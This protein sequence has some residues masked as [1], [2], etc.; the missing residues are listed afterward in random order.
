MVPTSAYGTAYSYTLPRATGFLKAFQNAEL[1]EYAVPC[2]R[3]LSEDVDIFQKSAER[4]GE[5][6]HD[7]RVSRLSTWMSTVGDPVMTRT[8]HHFSQKIHIRRP[9]IETCVP[10]APGVRGFCQCI[11]L[12]LKLVCRKYPQKDEFRTKKILN[13]EFLYEISSFCTLSENNSLLHGNISC[14]CIFL[15]KNGV[16]NTNRT[17]RVA[18]SNSPQ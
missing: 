18:D 1:P 7:V 10:H 8:T 4:Q 3:C 6:G 15:A 5:S 14:F 9:Y 13:Q 16:F 12:T 11:Q 2:R 17:P